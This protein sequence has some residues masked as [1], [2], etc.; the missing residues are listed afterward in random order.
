MIHATTLEDIGSSA[1][2]FPLSYAVMA[3][4]AFPF[5]F[6]PLYLRNHAGEESEEE[7]VRSMGAFTTTWRHHRPGTVQSSG[8][9]PP[10]PQAPIDPH[11][12]QCR[13]PGIAFDEKSSHGW[14]FNIDIP[15]R[16]TLEGIGSLNSFYYHKHSC[17]KPRSVRVW[18]ASIKKPKNRRST[19]LKST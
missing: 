2:E 13:Q 17:S 10:Q 11:Y 19:T 16:G 15:L 8:S 9:P 14:R 18:Q 4:A 3:S 5:I 7:Y 12:H 6:N 1:N